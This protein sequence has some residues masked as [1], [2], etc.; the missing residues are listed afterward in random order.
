MDA[1]LELEPEPEPLKKTQEPERVKKIRS[2]SR[3][4]SCLKENKESHPEP[5]K[6]LPAPQPWFIQISKSY[7]KI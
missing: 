6:N 4:R 7:D 5:L 1:E 2:W 3:S